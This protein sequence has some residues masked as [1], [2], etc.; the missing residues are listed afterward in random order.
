MSA[1]AEN[2]SHL[3]QRVEVKHADMSGRPGAR[4]IQV[5]T[6]RVSGHVIESAIAAHQLNLDDLVR[7]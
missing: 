7:A 4:D 2:I 6:V 5:A 3:G 1:G